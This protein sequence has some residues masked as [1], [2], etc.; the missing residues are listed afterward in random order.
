MI[1][2][3]AVVLGALAA[4]LLVRPAR[5]TPESMAAAIRAFAGGIAP[6]R[7]RVKLEMP[8]LVENGNAVPVTVSVE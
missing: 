8:A 5:A 7:G 6:T 2:R 1:G 4:T 3:R